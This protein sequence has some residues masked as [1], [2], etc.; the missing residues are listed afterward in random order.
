[1]RCLGEFLIA[2][3]RFQSRIDL[4]A[5]CHRTAAHSVFAAAIGDHIEDLLHLEPRH[6]LFDHRDPLRVWW[7]GAQEAVAGIGDALK[8]G[9]AAYSVIARSF[10]QDRAEAVGLEFVIRGIGPRANG[11]SEVHSDINSRLASAENGG[12]STPQDRASCGGCAGLGDVARNMVRGLM[13]QDKGQLVVIGEIREDLFGEGQNRTA[14]PIQRLIGIGA[15]A[16]VAVQND[17]EIAV[18]I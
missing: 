8:E 1:M 4:G 10:R 14:I 15:L 13:A 5:V 7:M 16:R 2:F 3:Q 11:C 9:R 17:P 6:G 18:H 12:Q